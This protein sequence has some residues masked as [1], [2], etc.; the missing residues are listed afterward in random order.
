MRKFPSDPNFHFVFVQKL[1]E[2]F[3]T[4][5]SNIRSE[6]GNKTTIILLRE[7]ENSRRL[8]EF[9]E[10]DFSRQSCGGD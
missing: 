7:F 9:E 8:R 10:I 4:F 3:K 2:L 5:I 6:N 1:P